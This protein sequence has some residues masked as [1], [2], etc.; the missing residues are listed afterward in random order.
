M[1]ERNSENLNIQRDMHIQRNGKSAFTLI[2][3]MIVIA[4]IGVLA[5]IAIPNLIRS[6][7]TTEKNACIKNL[8]EIEGAKQQWALEKHLNG[9]ADTVIPEVDTYIKGGSPSCPGGGRY[10]YGKINENVICT[11]TGHSL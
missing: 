6:R 7:L 1:G 3:I 9:G 5:A 8:Q 10:T 11:I 4:I 2:E